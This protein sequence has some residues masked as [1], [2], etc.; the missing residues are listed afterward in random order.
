MRAPP[1]ARGRT[2]SALC[3]GTPPRCLW[4]ADSNILLD[5]QWGQVRGH[6]AHS[7]CTWSSEAQEPP[8]SRVPGALVLEG[9]D[10]VGATG[11]RPLCAGR[12][13]Q[14]LR[15]G[16]LGP[17]SSALIV[18]PGPAGGDRVPWVRPRVHTLPLWAR[19]LVGRS[20]RSSRR[21][22]ALSE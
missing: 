2:L 8:E 20:V 19:G 22:V 3:G 16:A 1:G 7:P 13:A 9:Q 15:G 4:T 10:G 6:A 12:S 11:Y 17:L 14:R 21:A 5:G 18:P